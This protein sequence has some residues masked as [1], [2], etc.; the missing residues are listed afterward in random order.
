MLMTFTPLLLFP[1]MSNL[2]LFLKKICI[3]KI[4]SRSD[5]KFLKLNPSKFDLV[6]FSKFFQLIE[7]LPFITVS[8]NLSLAPSSPIHSLGFSF[9][10]SLSL[11]P[12]MESVAKS[13]F[14]PLRRIKQPKLF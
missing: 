14:F 9:D 11:I 8:S 6:Y 7:Y 1:Y 13:S 4:F 2:L 12:Q 5:T 10:F 3:G